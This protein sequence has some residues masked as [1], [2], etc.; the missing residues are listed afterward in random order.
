MTRPRKTAMM[1]AKGEK[2]TAADRLVGERWG[3]SAHL[4]EKARHEMKAQVFS[5]WPVWDEIA[6]F[7]RKKS[8]RIS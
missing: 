1:I 4:V 5:S 8:V 7:A 3:L 6:E 2:K